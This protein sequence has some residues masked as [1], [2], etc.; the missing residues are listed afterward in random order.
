[1]MMYQ[2]W[3]TPHQK[4]LP[5]SSVMLSVQFATLLRA[6]SIAIMLVSLLSH[7]HSSILS[8]KGQQQQPRITITMNMCPIFV[9]ALVSYIAS[10]IPLLSRQS[11]TIC[12]FVIRA[13]QP[14]SPI[15][16]SSL[17]ASDGHFWFGKSTSS[18]CPTDSDPPC[19]IRTETTFL[20]SDDGRAS[21]VRT[22]E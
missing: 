8:V 15:H 6:I 18:S 19:P 20:V 7:Y 1:M 2:V 9:I 12:P 5:T 14:G 21:L 11:K 10:A 13:S 3:L 22:S 4:R 16:L 17:N